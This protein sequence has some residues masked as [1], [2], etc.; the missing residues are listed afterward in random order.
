MGY[1]RFESIVPEKNRYRFYVVYWQPTL[2]G[3]WAVVRT[4]GRIGQGPRGRRVQECAGY[5][6]A[7]AL[8]A[9]QVER[10]LRRGYRVVGVS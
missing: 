8:A 10:R 6:E 4:W 7:L 5:E 2:W 1:V 3:T 9:E